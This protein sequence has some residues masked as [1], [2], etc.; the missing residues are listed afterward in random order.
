MEALAVVKTEESVVAQPIPFVDAVW[1]L[2][3]WANEQHIDCPDVSAATSV[4]DEDESWWLYDEDD[5]LIAHV[6]YD[7]HGKLSVL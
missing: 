6:G 5:K 4:V 1:E 7:N 3:N 2:R